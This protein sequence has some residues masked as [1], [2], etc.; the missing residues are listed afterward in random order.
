MRLQLKLFLQTVKQQLL[1][2]TIRSYLKL[3]R[4][5]S[6]QKLATFLGQDVDTL[7]VAL[8]QCKV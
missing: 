7:R 1:Q 8:H 4:S 3:Y 2:P 5:I 6:I